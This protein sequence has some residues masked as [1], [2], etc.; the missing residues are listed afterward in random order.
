MTHQLKFVYIY[1]NINYIYKKYIYK[2]INNSFY[3]HC[4]YCLIDSLYMYI[5]FIHIYVMY[6]RK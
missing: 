1:L 4:D 2:F 3:C 5:C 6:D